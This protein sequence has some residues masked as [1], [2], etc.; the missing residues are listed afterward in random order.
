MKHGVKRSVRAVLTLAPLALLFLAGCAH[1]PCMQ[2]DVQAFV[3]RTRQAH[4][5]YAIGLT[6]DAARQ[7]P[8]TQPGQSQP[9]RRAEMCSAWMLR[10][11]PAF[12]PGNGQGRYVRE[13]QNFKVVRLATGYEVTLSQP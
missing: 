9:S 10:R 12:Q 7:T 4:D 1:S 3:N 5:M 8:I 2:P 6:D 13:Q 11:N